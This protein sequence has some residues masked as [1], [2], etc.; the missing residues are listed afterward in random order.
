M[1]KIIDRS[2]KGAA[3]SAPENDANLSSLSGINAPITATTHTIDV[4]DQND[5]IEYFNASA[6]AVTLPAIS[7]VSLTFIHTDDFKVTL[8]NIGA[9]IVTITRAST[10][11]FD[12]GSTTKTLAQYEWITIQTDSGLT[13]WN[14][15]N[16]SNASKVD[17]L[18][19][20][21]FLRSDTNDTATGDLTLSGANTHSG[22]NTFIAGVTFSAN[23]GLDGGWDING[24]AVSATGAELSLNNGLSVIRSTYAGLVTTTTV[25]GD[26]GFT[27]V[28]SSAGAYTVTHNLGIVGTNNIITVVSATNGAHSASIIQDTSN[29][30]SVTTRNTTTD[31]YENGAFKFILSVQAQ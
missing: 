20:S 17:G 16:S 6:I 19:A 27:V 28:N 22:I 25:F 26:S 14:V 4:D 13:K 10:N 9:G 21:Q 24:T 29:S 3:I 5:I 12:D 31:V 2:G 8:K 1:T 7:T 18:D 11:T 23:V 15:I 30:F